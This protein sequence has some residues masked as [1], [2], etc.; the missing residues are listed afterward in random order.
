MSQNC[1]DCARARQARG[2]ELPVDVA[3]GSFQRM[4]TVVEIEGAI[5]RLSKAELS[6]LARWFEEYQQMVFASSE[7]FAM[8]DREEEETCRKPNAGNCG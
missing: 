2:I 4:S 5:E 3:D 1:E 8:Y 7:I 6:E